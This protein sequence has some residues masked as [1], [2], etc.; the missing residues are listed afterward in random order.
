M[1]SP[2]ETLL[3]AS[4]FRG[5]CLQEPHQVLTV[6]TGEESPLSDEGRASPNLNHN[7]Q[8]SSTI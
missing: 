1:D 7:K 4:P 8:T 3:G 2:S 6:R 5:F